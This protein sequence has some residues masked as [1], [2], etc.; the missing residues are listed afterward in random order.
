MSTYLG[1]NAY[2]KALAGNS[3]NGRGIPSRIT[4]YSG[5]IFGRQVHLPQNKLK[6][7]LSTYLLSPYVQG[8]KPG[9]LAMPLR[10]FLAHTYDVIKNMLIR[11]VQKTC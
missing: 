2:Y 4:H 11:E 9:A 7:L 5:L 1:M 3:Y 8:I 10:S 6:F